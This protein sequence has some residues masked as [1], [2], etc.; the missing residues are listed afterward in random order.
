VLF[1][2]AGTD[3]LLSALA[4]PWFLVVTG[5]VGIYQWWT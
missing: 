2:L 5:F 3:T 4:S 1:A